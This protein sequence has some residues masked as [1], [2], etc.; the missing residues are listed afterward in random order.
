MSDHSERPP[1]RPA[2]EPPDPCPGSPALPS[3]VSL[4]PYVGPVLDRPD[5]HG[6]APPVDVDP[7]STVAR[8]DVMA[9]TRD[10]AVTV[11]PVS[12]SEGDTAVGD[13]SR[14]GT[15]GSRG[16]R[17]R[18]GPAVGRSLVGRSP[19]ERVLVGWVLVGRSLAGR[20]LVG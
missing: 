3:S 20:E 17:G 7:A 5:P 2:P 10:G 12:L 8:D 4:P 16:R 1:D 9:G 18:V 15:V 14:A 6:P 19:A 13:R 11:V